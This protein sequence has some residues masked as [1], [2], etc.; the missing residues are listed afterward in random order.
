MMTQDEKLA[1]LEGYFKLLDESE[2][3]ETA[4]SHASYIKGMIGAWMADGSLDPKVWSELYTR[5]EAMLQPKFTLKSV[6]QGVQ[7]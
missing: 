5:T 2:F 7:F 1:S 3:Y 4:I 6:T